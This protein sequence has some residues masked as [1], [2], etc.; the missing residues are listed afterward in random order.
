MACR[1]AGDS[2]FTIAHLPAMSFTVRI[3]AALPLRFF[4][5]GLQSLFVQNP[6]GVFF[7]H[8]TLFCQDQAIF[9]PG[10]CAAAIRNDFPE[11]VPI[12]FDTLDGPNKVWYIQ[13]G[14]RFGFIFFFFGAP[15][16][17]PRIRSL[18]SH[19][20]VCGPERPAATPSFQIYNTVWIFISITYG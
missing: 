1:C 2:F 12:A 13:H 18:R 17:K 14:G 8:P 5:P 4:I 9:A 20:T 19:R 16:R 3:A 6:A 10:T 11:A 15:I 7:C